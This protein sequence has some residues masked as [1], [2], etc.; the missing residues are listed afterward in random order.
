MGPGGCRAG[1]FPVLSEKFVWTSIQSL[2][3]KLMT[4]PKRTKT[5]DPL[6]I[7]PMPL[8][9]YAYLPL[10]LKPLP[11]VIICLSSPERVLGFDFDI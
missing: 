4:L 9:S 2:A 8:L 11:Y 10:M 7:S 5:G 1:S 3:I 6:P